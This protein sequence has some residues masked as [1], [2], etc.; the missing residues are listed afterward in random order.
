[1]RAEVS[2][3]N[4]AWHVVDFFIRVS[5]L[6]LA[7]LC[8]NGVIFVTTDSDAE[9]PATSNA[10]SAAEFLIE[11]DGGVV[12]FLSEDGRAEEGSDS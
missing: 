2:A 1:V 10:S 8:D 11:G 12:V 9:V 4:T 7:T 3:G 6:V 5:I